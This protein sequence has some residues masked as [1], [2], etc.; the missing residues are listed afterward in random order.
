MTLDGGCDRRRVVQGNVK[1][2]C[3]PLYAFTPGLFI[4]VSA[5]RIGSPV[6]KS[7]VRKRSHSSDTHLSKTLVSQYAAIQ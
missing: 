1:R 6:F 3:G 5:I 7:I 2:A 4:P